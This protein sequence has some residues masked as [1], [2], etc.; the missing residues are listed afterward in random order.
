MRRLLI[1][2]VFTAMLVVSVYATSTRRLEADGFSLGSVGLEI[3]SVRD[4]RIVRESYWLRPVFTGLA[5][6][7][8]VTY[9]SSSLSYTG[10]DV[11]NGVDGWAQDSISGASVSVTTSPD[12][13]S[14]SLHAWYTGT[15]SGSCYVVY[16]ITTPYP[17]VN[18]SATAYLS[19]STGSNSL[20]NTGSGVEI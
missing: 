7:K 18:A 14:N 6:V 16:R 12:G 20:Y 9:S 2:A 19:Q 13:V 5:W 15:S 1:L 3:L 4:G 8:S 10:A 11:Y 17:I